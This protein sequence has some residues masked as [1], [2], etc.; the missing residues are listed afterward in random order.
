M[1]IRLRHHLPVPSQYKGGRPRVKGKRGSG[2]AV[3][4]KEESILG[5]SLELFWGKCLTRM[6]SHPKEVNMSWSH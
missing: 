5:F 6:A 4:R 3:E 1:H 2:L